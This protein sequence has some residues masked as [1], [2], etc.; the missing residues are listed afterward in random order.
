MFLSAPCFLATTL[1]GVLIKKIASH[2]TTRAPFATALHWSFSLTLSLCFA[3]ICN[4]SSS[5]IYIYVYNLLFSAC[6]R[7]NTVW[8]ICGFAGGKL[9]FCHCIT[10]HYKDPNPKKIIFYF[11]YY[12][13]YVFNLTYL[14]QIHYKYECEHCTMCK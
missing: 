2:A 11:C 12:N 7:I 4:S 1:S 13:I 10:L 5:D 3:G 8:R 14:I 6:S 9:L